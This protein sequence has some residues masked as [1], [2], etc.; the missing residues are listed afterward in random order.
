MANSV[1][2]QRIAL[3]DVDATSDMVGSVPY[4]T[5]IV[6]AGLVQA[7]GDILGHVEVVVRLQADDHAAVPRQ[8][9]SAP[10]RF[11]DVVSHG[12][13]GRSPRHGA[14][15]DAQERS[16]KI[17]REPAVL[18]RLLCTRPTLLSRG[19]IE[20]GAQGQA[21]ETDSRIA[22]PL[23]RLASCSLRGVEL[24]PVAVSPLHAQ[25][26]AIVAVGRGGR[27]ELGKAPLRCGRA[28]EANFHLLLLIFLVRSAI[29]V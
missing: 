26:N 14:T 16:T 23:P 12:L 17:G 1:S 25:L 7:R 10:E 9:S 22:A 11:G 3:V 28:H 4:G 21:T 18:F 27:Y 13:H 15:E 6:S 2:E 19:Q 20:S 29:H 8:V 5:E 24:Q